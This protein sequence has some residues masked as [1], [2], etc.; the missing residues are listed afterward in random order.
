MIGTPNRLAIVA[1]GP[2]SHDYI[3]D[4]ESAGGRHVL[5]DQVWVVNTYAGILDH[6][7][8]LHMDDLRAQEARAAAGNRKIGALLAALRTHGKPIITSRAY[9]DYPAS[10]AFPLEQAVNALDC[11]NA[12]DSTVDYGMAL[13]LMLK[14]R[15]ITLYGCDFNWRGASEVEPGRSSLSYWVGRAQERGVIVKIARHSTLMNAAGKPGP[16]FYGYDGADVKV[17]V[18]DGRAR[19][20]M[21]PREPPA[22]G[23]IEQRYSH[24]RAA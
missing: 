16:R 24:Q 21:T 13:A 18:L 4:T 8:L 17:Q 7:I 19:V 20:T 11:I 15:E 5:F 1:L 22:A 12:F 9:P 10:V 14:A 23:E 2:S 3:V 6:D